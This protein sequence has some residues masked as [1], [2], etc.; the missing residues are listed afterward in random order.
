VGAGGHLATSTMGTGFFPGVKRP[1]LG[2]DHPPPSSPEVKERVELYLYPLWAFVA[3]PSVTFT[4][5]FMLFCKSENIGP[6]VHVLV[7]Y[8][9]G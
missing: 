4:F 9:S 6:K 1:G 5:T 2:V 3:C 8:S 7:S